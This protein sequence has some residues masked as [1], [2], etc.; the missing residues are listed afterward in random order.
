MNLLFASMVSFLFTALSVLIGLG[1]THWDHRLQGTGDAEAQCEVLTSSQLAGL[2][3]WQ[4]MTNT[5][6]TFNLTV[7]PNGVNLLV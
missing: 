1:T 7:G 3:A 2:R 6:C 5:T 4:L